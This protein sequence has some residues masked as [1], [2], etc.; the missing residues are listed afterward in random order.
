MTSQ[1]GQPTRGA[2]H[3]TIWSMDDPTLARSGCKERP[4]LVCPLDCPITAPLSPD[5]AR[6]DWHTPRLC[7]DSLLIDALSLSSLSATIM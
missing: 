5:V 7:L 6:L 3:G 4:W 1:T 2:N